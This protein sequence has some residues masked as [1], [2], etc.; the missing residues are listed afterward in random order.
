MFITVLKISTHIYNDKARKFRDLMLSQ[1][2]LAT[3]IAYGKKRRTPIAFGSE[4]DFK[5]QYL[6]QLFSEDNE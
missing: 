6:E 1:Y 5:N 4:E 3:K 2:Q